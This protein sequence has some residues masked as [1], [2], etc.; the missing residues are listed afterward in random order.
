MI[1]CFYSPKYHQGIFHFDR[2][3]KRK[4]Q[5]DS[6]IKPNWVYETLIKKPFI[7]VVKPSLVAEKDL[8]R[9]HSK[10][11]L[12]ALKN[13]KPK[14][15]A[16]S[17]GLRW[18]PR[19]FESVLYSVSGFYSAAKEAL[20]SGISASLSTNFHHARRGRGSSFCVL[21]GTAITVLKLIEEGT[22]KRIVVLDCDLHLGD[23]TAS[24]LEKK[25]GVLVIDI[26]GSL[27][28]GNISGDFEGSNLF[29]FR[30]NSKMK[31]L[32]SLREAAKIVKSYKPNLVLYNAGVD[33]YQKDRYGG[34]WGID[35]EF[36]KKRDRFVFQE[37]VAKKIP[38][39]FILGGGY[40]K[41]RS[42]DGALRDNQKIREN[43][44]R[45]VNMHLNTFLE[46]SKV[47]SI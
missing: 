45:I 41:Y 30:V 21:N 26:F 10:R 34:I 9:A 28:K 2:G 11:Y 13:G 35:E 33:C 31:Y 15:L 29:R 46:G 22:I 43:R 44:R 39:A 25:E 24:I 6:V 42:L 20:K 23:G 12:K 36:I 4:Y 7:E 5:L 3:G 37:T 18:V 1:T 8:L 32:D 27:H 47:A 19:L 38:I 14:D 16:N 40:V 17:S